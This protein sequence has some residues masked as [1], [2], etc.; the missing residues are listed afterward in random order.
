MNDSNAPIISVVVPAYNV[1]ELARECLDSLLAQT[2]TNFEVICVDDGSTDA[3]LATLRE[4]ERRDSRIRVV[5]RENAGVSVARNQGVALATGKYLCFV[6]SDD[7]VAPEYLE[8]LVET[9]EKA[10]ADFVRFFQRKTL[11]KVFKRF[12]KAKQ[13]CDGR[14]RDLYVDPTIDERKLFVYLSGFHACWSCAYRRRFWLDNGISFP[15]G[16]R[17]SEDTKVNYL[18]A[19]LANRLAFFEADLYRWRKRSGSASHPR[20][21][22]KLGPYADAITTHAQTREFFASSEKT[23]AL[24]EPLAEIFLFMQRNIQMPLIASERKLWRSL[25]DPLF[26]D[27]ARRALAEPRALPFR[28]RAFWLGLYDKNVVRRFF[29][30]VASET[31]RVCRR[32]EKRIKYEFVEKPKERKRANKD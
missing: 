2:L 23:V 7:S 1:E 10:N 4:Y 6:D 21:A 9:A 31:S 32:L 22:E 11:A 25:V 3:T 17:I 28:V 14:V 27:A 20:A 16:I 13:L 19:A 26:D 18:A 24:L 15:E 29:C 5:S 12:R 30:R 8:R